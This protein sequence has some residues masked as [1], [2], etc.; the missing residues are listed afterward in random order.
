MSANNNNKRIRRAIVEILF[1][2]G[3]CTREE[4]ANHLSR[5]KSVKTVPSLNSLSALLSKNPQV[6][7]VG[8][9]T[10]EMTSGVNAKH[11]LFDIDKEIV[12]SV[13]ELVYTRPLSVM[14]PS[15][16][17]NAKKCVSCGRNRLMPDHTQVCL[18]CLRSQ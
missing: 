12:H 5:I 8:K 11:M 15:E 3:P 4:V 6:I 1:E 17:A 9:A 10:V 18:S 14:T 13:D 16:R 7:Q 2:Y